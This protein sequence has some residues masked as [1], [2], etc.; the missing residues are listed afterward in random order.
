MPFVPDVL[1][2]AGKLEVLGVLCSILQCPEN[3]LAKQ[4]IIGTDGSHFSQPGE[5]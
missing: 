3:L 2:K 5:H 4:K 1:P